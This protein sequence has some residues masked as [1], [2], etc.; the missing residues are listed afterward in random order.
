MTITWGEG[1]IKIFTLFIFYSIHN[2][3]L[4]FISHQNDFISKY[5]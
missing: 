2:N 5:I 4:L 1:L 3:Q